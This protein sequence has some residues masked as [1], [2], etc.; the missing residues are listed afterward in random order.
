MHLKAHALY[1]NKE[2]EV[3]GVELITMIFILGGDRPLYLVVSLANLR[4]LKDDSMQKAVVFL[5]ASRIGPCRIRTPNE[6]NC[7]L[8]SP[9]L[10]PAGRYPI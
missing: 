8:P 5:I 7:S 10:A 4:C 2:S 9:D 1:G 3:K 6:K